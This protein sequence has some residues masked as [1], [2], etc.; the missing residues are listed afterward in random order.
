MSDPAPYYTEITPG[1]DEPRA[2]WVKASD[3]VRLRIGVWDAHTPEVKGTVFLLPGRTEYI[4]KYSLVATEFA[5]H[6]LSSLAI[7][8]RGQGIADRL[9]KDP[10]SGHVERFSDYSLDL[11]AMLAHGANMPKPWFIL[12]HSMGGA[13]GLRAVMERSEFK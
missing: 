4:E 12:G 7:D 8:W 13:I 5:K 9:V 11:D 1:T 3:G 2:S 6:G 10:M